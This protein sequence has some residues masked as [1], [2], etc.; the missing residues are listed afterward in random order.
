MISILLW[1]LPRPPPSSMYAAISCIHTALYM[2]A[3][4]AFPRAAVQTWCRNSVSLR[5][6][7]PHMLHPGRPLDAR[8][9]QQHSLRG[10]LGSRGL[11]SHL[12]FSLPDAYR[13]ITGRRVLPVLL[14]HAPVGRV[15][16]RRVW[17]HLR[18]GTSC[19]GGCPAYTVARDPSPTP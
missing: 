11:R 12:L 13:S 7:G 3:L 14:W 19:D 10:H 9:L 17:Q 16:H 1:G 5:S 15:G 8:S 4:G 18:S 6:P 2:F